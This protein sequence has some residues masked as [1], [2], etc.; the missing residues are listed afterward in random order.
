MLTLAL[1]GSNWVQTSRNDLCPTANATQQGICMSAWTRGAALGALVAAATAAPLAVRAQSS[2][3]QLLRVGSQPTEFTADLIY[4]MNLGYFDQHGIKLDLQMMSNGAAT[5]AAILG[6]GL[7]IGITDPLSV[8]ESFVGGA[9]LVFI[10]PG[11]GFAPPWPMGFVTHPD[12]KVKAAKDLDGR[13][14][15]VPGLRNAP[16][17]MSYYWLDHN[18]GD[19][20]SV[21][22]IELPFSAGVPAILAKRI[23]GALFGE[24][25]LSQA[26]AAG[27]TI[28]LLEHNTS[29]ATWMVDGWVARRQW[30]DRNVDV[31]RRF[32]LAI[33]AANQWAN[34]HAADTVPMLAQFTKMSESTIRGMMPHPW[35]E[36][37]RPDLIQ[38]VLDTCT[39]YG[40][41]KAHVA[42]KD[43]FYIVR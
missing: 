4:A 25:F 31:I 32:G 6:G 13:T 28:T 27:L 41:L 42:A 10:A 36:T 7:D 11:A 17:I 29:A 39:K 20:K 22:W 33:R 9:D 21:K 3:T 15:A 38:S 8:A 14:I 43:L 1:T 16:G 26:R 37:L 35:I 24:P 34:T 19:S 40:V 5:G 12:L 2:G 23:D 18:G 30:V